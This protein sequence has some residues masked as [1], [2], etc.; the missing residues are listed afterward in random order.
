MTIMYNKGIRNTPLLKGYAMNDFLSQI[1]CEELTSYEPTAQDWEDYNE[2]L[3]EM[4]D[5]EPDVD[6][7]Q[8]WYDFDPDC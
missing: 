7:A 4:Y 6:E 2:Y 8:E 1:Q 3:E 5:D